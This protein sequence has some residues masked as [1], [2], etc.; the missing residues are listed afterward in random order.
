[1]FLAPQHTAWLCGRQR[2]LAHETSRLDRP[3]EGDSM[4]TDRYTK[5]VLTVIAAAL[6]WLCVR[7]FVS[8]APAQAGPGGGSPVVIVGLERVPGYRFDPLPVTGK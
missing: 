4:Q 8:P 5:T 1:M 7:D 3:E 6:V 2:N